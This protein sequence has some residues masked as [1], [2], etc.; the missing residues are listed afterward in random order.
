DSLGS[1]AGCLHP[2]AKNLRRPT[3]QVQSRHSALK[4]LVGIWSTAAVKP[5]EGKLGV[6]RKWQCRRLTAEFRDNILYDFSFE[7][8]TLLFRQ[9]I[10]LIKKLV[11]GPGK[12]IPEP[13]VRVTEGRLTRLESGHARYH[14]PI[15]L[16]ADARDEL[17]FHIFS[18]SHEH[19]TGGRT[20]DLAQVI[21]FNLSPNRA[22]MR[23]ES[24]HTDNHVVGDSEFS[25]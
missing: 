25:R 13:G 6:F 19:I 3:C 7:F 8:Y 14:R 10:S 5:V 12:Y 4:R 18:G 20:H 16:P 1:E 22:H 15:Y 24:A 11:Q 9:Q 21:R 17:T 2:R 23:V